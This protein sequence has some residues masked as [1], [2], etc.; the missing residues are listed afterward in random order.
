MFVLPNIDSLNQFHT[1]SAIIFSQSKYYKDV[2]LTARFKTITLGPIGCRG[3][4]SELVLGSDSAGVTE[5]IYV[6]CCIKCIVR[7]IPKVFY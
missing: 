6:D 1:P 5:P 2:L 7:M 4:Q 3:G